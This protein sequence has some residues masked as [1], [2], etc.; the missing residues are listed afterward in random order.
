[1][2]RENLPTPRVDREAAEPTV[3]KAGR[4]G[5]LRAILVTSAL[6][7]AGL[8]SVGTSKKPA[9][10]TPPP[11][12]PGPSTSGAGGSVP[13]KRSAISDVTPSGRGTDPSVGQR[14][15]GPGLARL[16]PGARA[17]PDGVFHGYLFATPGARECG[18]EMPSGAY[19]LCSVDRGRVLGCGSVP[20]RRGV[21]VFCQGGSYLTCQMGQDGRMQSCGSAY[22]G[23]TVTL[24]RGTL[25]RCCIHDG[26]VKYCTNDTDYICTAADRRPARPRP[27]PRTRPAPLGSPVEH[28]A[29]HP[30][31]PHPKPRRGSWER[32]EI[33]NGQVSH[34]RGWY[35]GQAVVFNDGAYRSCRIF[36][37]QISNCGS[38]YQG[39]AVAFRDRAFR[40]CRI[41]NGQIS[42]CGS[43][44]RGEAAVFREN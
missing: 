24:R 40:L 9:P 35:H 8:L 39:E 31:A 27:L 15:P 25:R 23:W 21:T 26:K 41:F 22:S 44:Y 5:V 3:S 36:N 11:P 13:A 12:P 7:V 17:L 4:F 14:G 20:M 2:R 28:V 34:C 6:A 38:W 43:W 16:P 37:G 33:F 18:E 32:C 30:V 42:H 1:M 19:H 10:A 29:P